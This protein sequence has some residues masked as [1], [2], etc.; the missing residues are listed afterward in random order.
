M[1]KCFFDNISF[2]D[3]QKKKCDSESKLALFNTRCSVLRFNFGLVKKNALP[4][5]KGKNF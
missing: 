4:D 3:Y 5:S 1:R 2:C